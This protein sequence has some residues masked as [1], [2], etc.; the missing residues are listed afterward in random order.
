MARLAWV[1]LVALLLF[2]CGSRQEQGEIHP[3]HITLGEEPC[4]E[5]GMTITDLR[6]ASAAVL[7]D[8]DYLLFD[9]IGDLAQH[10]TKQELP[11]GTRF[12]VYDYEDSE[13]WLAAEEATFVQSTAIHSPMGSGLAAFRDR[14]RAEAV[15]AE[16]GATLLS[17]EEVTA[18]R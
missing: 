2:G 10:Q 3:P 4:S 11:V 7:P 18:P 13:E 14:A 16:L 17:F 15:A 9:D 12:F 1:F 5:C 8:G 6:F